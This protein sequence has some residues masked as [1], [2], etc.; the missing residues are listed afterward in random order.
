VAFRV[1][2]RRSL[3]TNVLFDRL[4][5]LLENMES[6]SASAVCA[7]TDLLRQRPSH[8]RQTQ[9]R[10]EI[11]M[12]LTD[13]DRL[14]VILDQIACNPVFSLR[15]IPTEYWRVR[16]LARS[17]WTKSD[18]QFSGDRRQRTLDRSYCQAARLK[19]SDYLKAS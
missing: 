13:P 2:E 19:H 7:V 5:H 18:R 11:E 15:E 9:E 12:D 4:K 17:C 6:C 14:E 10:R 8:C 1:S 16:V 3:E